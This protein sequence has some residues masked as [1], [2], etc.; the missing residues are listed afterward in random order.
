MLLEKNAAN[1]KSEYINEV[2]KALRRL[3]LPKDTPVVKILAEA[4][5]E[6]D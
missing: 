4:K 6:I 2:M 3:R 1:G 5:A